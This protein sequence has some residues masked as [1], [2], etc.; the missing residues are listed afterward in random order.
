M[1]L[2][3]ALDTNKTLVKQIIVIGGMN[4][5]TFTQA[6]IAQHIATFIN[7]V[8]ANYVNA[9]IYIGF[10]AGT[11]EISSNGNLKRVRLYNNAYLGYREAGI[12]GA[13]FLD[14]IYFPMHFY[15]NYV[16]QN[17][18]NQTACNQ[19]AN[20][21]YN[22]L[23]GNK[24]NQYSTFVDLTLSNPIDISILANNIDTVLMNENLCIKSLSNCTLQ[25]DNTLTSPIL[26]LGNITSDYYRYTYPVSWIVKGIVFTDNTSI[27]TPL[28]FSINTNNQLICTILSTAYLEA[29]SLTIQPFSYNIPLLFS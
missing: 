15:N 4:D 27:Q 8:K 29:K 21:I 10:C 2:L 3:S 14:N 24:Y 19:I 20:A 17:H 26:N 6:N 13:I 25:F 28:E 18:P 9:K 16:D 1:S 22:E 23:N 5:H 7:Y 12:L 11:N